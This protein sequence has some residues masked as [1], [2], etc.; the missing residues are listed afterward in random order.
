MRRELFRHGC[1]ILQ[2][3]K[4]R[5]GSGVHCSTCWYDCVATQCGGGAR[6]YTGL[7]GAHQDSE[8]DQIFDPSP[9]AHFLGVEGGLHDGPAEHAH[10]HDRTAVVPAASHCTALPSYLQ[11][12]SSA[13]MHMTDALEH[14][15][16]KIK[17]VVSVSRARRATVV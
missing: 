8:W 6:Q 17:V 2:G 16:V 13:R 7:R 11:P 1:V 10:R 15:R 14:R 9:R 12:R 5:S 4:T 3:A